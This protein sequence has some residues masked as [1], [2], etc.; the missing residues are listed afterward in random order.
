MPKKSL[1]REFYPP[2]KVLGHKGFSTNFS[3][4]NDIKT[5]MVYPIQIDLNKVWLAWDCFQRFKFVFGRVARGWSSEKC[6]ALERVEVQGTSKFESILFGYCIDLVLNIRSWKTN[7]GHFPF[8]KNYKKV[9]LLRCYLTIKKKSQK[10]P[11]D[12]TLPFHRH[13]SYCIEYPYEYVRVLETNLMLLLSLFGGIFWDL[14]DIY[15]WLIFV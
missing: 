2:H 1:K 8:S 13:H 12:V 11:P 4:P 3:K 15:S 7:L 6:A 9:D 14:L 10:P 5:E